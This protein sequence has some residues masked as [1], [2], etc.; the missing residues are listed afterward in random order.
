L[1]GFLERPRKLLPV[2]AG[3]IPNAPD[4]LGRYPNILALKK[5][6]AGFSPAALNLRVNGSQP[7]LASG[8]V[9]CSRHAADPGSLFAWPLDRW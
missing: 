7:P 3:A 8:P 1:V 6:R 9:S 5:D 4:R 2:L